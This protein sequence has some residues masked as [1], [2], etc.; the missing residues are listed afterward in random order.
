MV[1]IYTPAADFTG[2]DTFQYKANDGAADSNVANVTINVNQFLAP[3]SL[4]LAGS[5]GA[6]TYGGTTTATATLTSNG[7][8]VANEKISFSLH[9]AN[10]GTATTDATGTATLSGISLAGCNA[11]TFASS[12]AASFVGDATYAGS[13]AAADL[14]V[15]KAPLTITAA[16]LSR[17]YGNPNLSPIGPL[18]GPLPI[19]ITAPTSRNTKPMFSGT[20]IGLKN[21]D[22]I[23]AT[24]STMATPAS[25]VGQYAIV[26][27]AVDSVPS[28]LNNYSVTLVNGTLTVT[29]ANQTI[30]WAAPGP[31]VYGTALGS[32]QL[33]A[34]VWVAGPAPAGAL[35]YGP[36]AGSIESAGSQSLSVTAAGTTD[37]NPATASATLDVLGPGVHV[38]GTELWLVA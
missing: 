16:S 24:Y 22:A 28:T 14:V 13:N 10:V 32:G 2:L 34:T 33:D 30:R 12:L 7:S 38:V 19:R 1:L 6:G 9:G 18:M 4:V 26:P 37:Y 23:T 27:A 15:N 36:P 35:T 20:I 11:G 3:S 21:G 17:S 31:V 29:K 5:S 8:P 25:P